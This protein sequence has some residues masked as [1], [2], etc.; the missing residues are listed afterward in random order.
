MTFGSVLPYRLCYRCLYTDVLSVCTFTC[1]SGGS[2]QDIDTHGHRAVSGLPFGCCKFIFSRGESN[3]CR[4]C[5]MSIFRSLSGIV[6]SLLNDSM[7]K[8]L[9]EPCVWNA[10]HN[11]N[12]K[13][14][15]KWIDSVPFVCGVGSRVPSHLIHLASGLCIVAAPVA[16]I[17]PK[18]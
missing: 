11:Q 2:V 12:G 17:Q 14:D 10:T 9:C 16:P 4:Y 8:K 13:H 1:V 5:A 18:S 6:R 7:Y 3:W 15:M